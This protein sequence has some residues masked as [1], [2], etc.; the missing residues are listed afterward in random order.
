MKPPLKDQ[1]T[2]N[3]NVKDGV[4]LLVVGAIKKEKPMTEEEIAKRKQKEEEL[5]KIKEEMK[6]NKHQRIVKN[7]KE[8]GIK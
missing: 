3:K 8:K 4:E 5:E 6:L 1:E 2:F 7:L